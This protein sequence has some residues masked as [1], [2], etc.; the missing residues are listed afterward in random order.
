MITLRALKF[1]A[2]VASRLTTLGLLSLASGP[3]H[4]DE[5]AALPECIKASTSVGCEGKCQH[6]TVQNS[7]GGTLKIHIHKKPEK[8]GAICPDL[9]DK[10]PTGT[11]QWQTK[12]CRFTTV[13]L[14]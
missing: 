8:L 14:K 1:W 11:W 13:H 3:M 7:C 12:R 6:L 4:A 2:A 5:G 9:T 10:L